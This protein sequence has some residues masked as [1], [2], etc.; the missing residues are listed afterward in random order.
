MARIAYEHIFDY[1]KVKFE[2]PHCHKV[3]EHIFEIPKEGGSLTQLFTCKECSEIFETETAWDVYAIEIKG[4]SQESIKNFWPIKYENYLNKET[5]LLDSAEE[6]HN[7]RQIIEKT[8]TIDKSL[9]DYLYRLL[10]CSVIS[11]FDNYA[12]KAIGRRIFSVH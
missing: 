11:V 3:I 7:L 12:H 2:C 10:W 8:D 4:I 9:R 5:E 1:I 6:I